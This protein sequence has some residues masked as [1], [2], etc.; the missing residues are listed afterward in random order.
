MSCSSIKP[1]TTVTSVTTGSSYSYPPEW[2]APY[3]HPIYSA[4]STPA[5]DN[6]YE[7]LPSGNPFPR[8]SN[9][10]VDPTVISNHISSKLVTINYPVDVPS[11]GTYKGITR[12]DTTPPGLS[13][14]PENYARGNIN[15]AKAFA[16][17]AGRLRA[18]LQNE[19]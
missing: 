17:A 3:P 10:T 8:D 18:N 9:G 1:V 15:P 11:T 2:K 6:L 16:Q 12:V 5:A 7:C 19:Y 14:D 13:N 4:T